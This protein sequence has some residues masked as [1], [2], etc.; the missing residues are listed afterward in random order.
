[1]KLALACLALLALGLPSHAATLAASPTTLDAAVYAAKSGDI[2]A[3]PAG[4]YAPFRGKSRVGLTFK[5]A[6]GAI[7][8]GWYWQNGKDLTFDGC[9]FKPAVYQGF[10][11]DGVDG[12]TITNSKFVDTGLKVVNGKRVSVDKTVFLR[13]S[14]GVSGTHVYGLSV[15]RSAFR[16]SSSDGIQCGGC[17]D[18]VID[19]NTFDG[20]E[21][22]GSQHP[23]FAQFWSLDGVITARVQITDNVAVG[24]SQGFCSFNGAAGGIEDVYMARN[25]VWTGMKWAAAFVN[26]RRIVMED[27]EFRAITGALAQPAIDARMG[28]VIEFRGKNTI[29]GLPITAK[30]IVLK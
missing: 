1:M 3:L 26:G 23:D 28:T 17:T 6:P 16:L 18:V 2:I 9:T 29:N 30:Q 10:R 4:D 25:R 5:C 24:N 12:L 22:P 27:N 13:S 15:T 7:I 20:T 8:N 19:H 14:T 11:I 21:R